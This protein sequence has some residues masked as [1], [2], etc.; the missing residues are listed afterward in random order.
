[1]YP[2][3]L[4]YTGEHEWIRVE[5]GSGVVGITHFAQD[6]LGD[7]VYVEL[8][9]TGRVVKAG[10]AFGAVESVK[11]VSDLYSPVGGTV[12]GV[13]AELAGRPE[14]VN[15]DPYGEGWMIVIELADPGEADGLL[16]ARA[17]QELLKEG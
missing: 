2:E 3:N 1:M 4:R 17:Y 11:S 6:A 10:E 16:S 14:L 13:N 15:Q 8:P 5:G 12:T 7:V 9:E